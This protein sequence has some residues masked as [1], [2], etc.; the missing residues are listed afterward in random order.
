M[1]F[2]KND[3]LRTI[4]AAGID[5]DVR[6]RK[7]GLSALVGIDLHS[8]GG[9]VALSFFVRHVVNR[10]KGVFTFNGKF[11]AAVDSNA[12]IN[13]VSETDVFRVIRQVFGVNRAS[14]VGDDKRVAA[15]TARG[16]AARMATVSGLRRAKREWLCS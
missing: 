15:M 13:A 9:V 10:E 16:A 7:V 4:G 5:S 14:A 1:R 12:G 8:E 2:G 6:A 3:A 11:A